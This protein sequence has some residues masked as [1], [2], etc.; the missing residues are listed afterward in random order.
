MSIFVDAVKK[1]LRSKNGMLTKDD[2]DR[3]LFDVTQDV[4]ISP[5]LQEISVAFEADVHQAYTVKEAVSLVEKV[6][7]LI[8]VDK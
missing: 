2:I 3:V 1:V 6:E 8:M 4:G 5:M 7:R